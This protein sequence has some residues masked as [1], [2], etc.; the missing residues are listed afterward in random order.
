MVMIFSRVAARGLELAARVER[1]HSHRHVFP[2]QWRAAGL[3]VLVQEQQ[4]Y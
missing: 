2:A 1:Q 4:G 3:H